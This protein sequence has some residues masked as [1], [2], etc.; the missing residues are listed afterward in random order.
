[1]IT[2]GQR[3]GTNSLRALTLLVIA[4]STAYGGQSPRANQSQTGN[5][6]PNGSSAQPATRGAS[7]LL[8]SPEE[9]YRIGLNDVLDIKV[10]SAPELT[11]TYRVTA[12]GTFLMP[13]VGRVAA[14]K[15]TTEELAEFITEKLRGDYLKDPKVS[16]IVR[17]FNSRSFF[18]QGSVRSP[19]V[20]Q[21]EGKPSMLELITLA[22]GL[23][24]THGA[25]AFIIR[26]IKA[27]APD[28]AGKPG[29]NASIHQDPPSDESPR[30]EMSS[31][32]ISGLLR[33]NFNQNVSLEAGDIVNI[34]PTDV[35]FVAG[36]VNAPGS[37]QLKEGTS[38]RQAI[39]LAQG[40]NFKAATSR[41]I[42]FRENAAGKREELHVD[43]AAVMSGKKEDITIAAN[44][45]IMVP[46]S[47]TRS[48]GGALLRAFGMTAVSRFP[49]P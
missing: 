24:E 1:M 12:A 42:I 49:I 21:I 18:I 44:D 2:I 41:G 13:W 48:I 23:S 3:L 37:F 8:V 40:T 30:Y 7:A 4:S 15:K 29:T 27:Q 33:G 34:P 26:R 19:G 28:G 36:E 32:N 11:Q 17:E 16:V 9:D 20:F 46:N 47:R 22:G 5:V 14:A 43:I 31:V 35:F 38:L 6:S 45:I 10:E 39:S 25:N